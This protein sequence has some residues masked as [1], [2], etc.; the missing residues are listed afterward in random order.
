[1]SAIPHS[2][3]LLIAFALATL[4]LTSGC[5]GVIRV[6][7]LPESSGFVYIASDEESPE[8]NLLLCDVKKP[9]VRILARDVDGWAT[10]AVSRD[11]K[12]IA[13]VSAG[14]LIGKPQVGV[15]VFDHAGK[16]LH[17][18]SS[19]PWQAPNRGENSILPAVLWSPT[20]DRLLVEYHGYSCFYDPKKEKQTPLQ[21]QLVWVELTG[22]RPDSK[23]FITR[24]PKGFR[25]VDWSGK[26]RP[27][28]GVDHVLAGRRRPGENFGFGRA[29]PSRWDGPVAEF[30]DLE[31]RE[32]FRLDTDELVYTRLPGLGMGRNDRRWQN[33][34]FSFPRGVR[35]EVSTGQDADELQFRQVIGVHPGGKKVQ[36]LKTYME[37]LALYPSPDRRWVVAY[38]GLL[39]L[40][41][42]DV[43]VIHASGASFTPRL[44]AKVT[45]RLAAK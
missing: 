39:E 12:Q 38:W 1:M 18:S 43:R 4:L 30:T 28:R 23:G 31:S 35:L 37:W 11:S 40:P 33:Y 3:R 42:W 26:E 5:Y 29:L 9:T 10:P 22:Q 8:F 19:L 16:L 6:S 25:F 14:G 2:R 27:L 17:S 21:G 7:W 20:G 15:R 44:P 13:V 41:N 32:R 45:P 36:L 24:S 34:T